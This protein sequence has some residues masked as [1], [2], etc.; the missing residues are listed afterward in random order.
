[1]ATSIASIIAEAAAASS[2][3]PLPCETASVA[4]FGRMAAQTGMPTSSSPVSRASLVTPNSSSRGRS[5]ASVY[6]GATT[7]L[8]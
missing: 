4:A 3:T 6:A 1:V 7:R 8:E 5:A 2:S